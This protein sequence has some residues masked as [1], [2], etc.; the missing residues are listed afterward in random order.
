LLPGS[1]IPVI[2]PEQLEAESPDAL[3][4]LP[5]NLIEELREQIPEKNL[6]TAI[7]VLKRW[8]P[9]LVPSALH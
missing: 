8:Q 5:W 7:P 9:L 4:L 1:H 6:V 2:S 3:L